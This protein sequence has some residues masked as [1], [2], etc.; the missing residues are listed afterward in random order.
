MP[1]ISHKLVLFCKSYRSD[2]H[3]VKCLLNSILRNNAENIPF[4]ISVPHE[5]SRVFVDTLGTSGYVLLNDSDILSA[6]PDLRGNGWVGQQIVKMAFWKTGLAENTVVLD[7]DS[8]FIR[9]FF[10]KDFIADQQKN[11]PYTVLH[12]QHEL[13]LWSC[14]KTRFLGFDP[15]KSF[16]DCRQPILDI[17]DV[18]AGAVIYDDGPSPVIWST[19]VWKMLLETYMSPNNLS[20]ADLLKT[21]ASEFSWY[22]IFLRA[23]QAIPIYPVEPLFKVFHYAQQYNEYKTQGYTEQDIAKVKLGIVMQSNWGSPTKY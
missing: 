3:R 18:G 20:Y 7:S 9:P 21:S 14:N 5:D 4:F 1:D 13:F 10:Y 11:I 15:Q 6:S 23:T 12:Q 17:F 8:Y 22:G 16:S 2:V 19:K